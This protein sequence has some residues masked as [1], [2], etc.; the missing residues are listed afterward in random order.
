M[1][2]RIVEIPV[3]YE[4]EFGPDLDYVAEHNG[5]TP[6]EVIN[7][8]SSGSYLVYM[9]GFAPGFPFIGGM[10]EQIAAPRRDTPV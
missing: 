2:A 5:L 9:I 10:S 6:D 7:I 8:H 4:G 3:C 1:E